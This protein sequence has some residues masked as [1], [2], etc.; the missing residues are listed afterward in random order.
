MELSNLNIKHSL[1][2]SLGANINSKFGSPINSLIES[3]PQIEQIIYNLIRSTQENQFEKNFLK[4]IFNWS[5]LYRTSPHE[6]EVIQPDFI[7]CLLLVESDLLPIPS[8]EKAKYLLNAFKDI[9]RNF[10]RIKSINEQRWLPRS[11]DID[12]IWWDNLNI[13]DEELI[14]PHPRFKI[15]NFVIAPLSEVLGNSQKV[16]KLN[17]NRWFVN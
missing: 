1:C 7:N 3:R 8:V 12:M 14:L 11:L 9:E 15:R 17:E 5:S 2:V 6:T 4:E 13:H 10:G 16:E